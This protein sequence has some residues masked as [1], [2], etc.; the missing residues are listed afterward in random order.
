MAKY[1]LTIAYPLMVSA[2]TK[3][4]GYVVELSDKETQI[5]PN[6]IALLWANLLSCGSSN[7]SLSIAKLAGRGLLFAGQSKKELLYQ[8]KKMHP[9]RQGIG[10]LLKETREDKID[11][12]YFSVRLGDKNFTL[13]DF[14]RHFWNNSNGINSIKSIISSAK[15]T[16]KSMSEEEMA[17]QIFIL[18]ENGLLFLKKKHIVNQ[19]STT[20]AGQPGLTGG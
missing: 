6:E 16:C 15:K 11:Y 17:N 1:Y 12:L 14:Q 10:S 4:D 7:D 13:S 18:I 9:Y 8:C 5:I 19:L 3:V 2:S 20:T